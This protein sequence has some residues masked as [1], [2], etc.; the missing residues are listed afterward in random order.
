MSIYYKVHNNIT[1]SQSVM[2]SQFKFIAMYN[3]IVFL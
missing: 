2:F 1:N 3:C